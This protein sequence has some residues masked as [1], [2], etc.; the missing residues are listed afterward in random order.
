M[1]DKINKKSFWDKCYAILSTELV[2]TREPEGLTK[3]IT[4]F[5]GVAMSL[6]MIFS[7][8]AVVPFYVFLTIYFGSTC[9]LVFIL[10]PAR[11]KSPNRLTIVDCLLIVATVAMV[12]YFIT[13]FEAMEDR[14]GMLSRQ[15]FFFGT[16]AVIVS[17]ESCRRVL[18][19]LLPGLGVFLIVYCLFGSY[20]PAAV[21]HKGFT[22]Q[23]IFE[24][25]FS[26]EGIFGVICRVYA[27]FIFL[28]ILFGAFL[29]AT[30]TG[31]FFIDL[32]LSLVGK[33]KGG[34]AKVAVLGSGFIGSIVG[35]GSANVAIT[36][37]F[38]IPMMKKTG[39]KPHIAAALEAAASIGGHITPPVMGSVIFLLASLT[40]TS[41]LDVVKISIIPAILWYF[42]LYVAIHFYAAKSGITGMKKEELPDFWSTFK[43][44][45]PLM[46]PVITLII[47][48]GKRYSPHMAAV[49]AIFC[50]FI[51][52]MIKKETRFTL[53]SLIQ[54][55]YKGAKNS[56]VLGA[57]AGTMGIILG[58]ITF[59]GLSL[60]FS[61][62]VL[63]YSH[64]ILPIAMVLILFAAYI[65]GM[66]MTVTPAYVVL[67]ILAAPALIEL[68][69][70][71]LTAHLAI[72]WF[73]QSSPLTPPFCLAAF[74]GAGI[75][76]ANPMQTGFASVRLGF[77]MY[78]VPFIMVY[79]APF[80]L[81]GSWWEICLTFLIS[82]LA[83]GMVAVAVIGFFKGPINWV[84][85]LLLVVAAG[86]LLFGNP[87]IQLIGLI[88]TV[89]IVFINWHSSETVEAAV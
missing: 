44:G 56:L 61:S 29:I 32:A 40:N 76:E 71:L 47:M 53:Q 73:S 8:L 68:G 81:N 13:Q 39:F 72:V 70:P 15:D 1:E 63:S 14:V 4:V 12:V 38:T 46:L 48:L 51:V 10:Y 30:K 87:M 60:K 7:A 43:R 37:I 3:N 54:T 25:M 17:L 57:T 74:V 6:F 67:A 89:A 86:L 26:L 78:V 77:V 21:A 2:K 31:D 36:G 66:G 84:L 9:V 24:F 83:I 27:T 34:A 82:F 88:V 75:A 58:G 42:S 55:L 49:Y 59:P 28:F 80:L 64:N 79:N 19:P 62:L 33:G 65:L 11:Q 22:L 35:S 50:M 85:R 45:W 18:G 52:A 16:L 41:Y 20:F 23:R 69:V 5:T